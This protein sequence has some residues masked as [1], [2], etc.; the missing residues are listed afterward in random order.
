M[1]IDSHHHFWNYDPVEYNWIDD[2]MKQ[3]RRDFLPPD[4]KNE[5]S[6]TSIEGVISVQARQSIEETEW[7]LKMAGEN[8]FIKGVTGWLPLIDPMV[9]KHLEKFSTDN[10][11]KAVR[12]VL[13]GEANEYMLEKNFNRGIKALR[14]FD[15][16]YEILINEKQLK[17]AI[18]LVD[19]HPDQIFVLDHIAKPLIKDG[20]ISPW[21]ENIIELSNRA[22]VHCKISG[23]VTEADYKSW[24]TENLSP[25][26]DVVLEAFGPERLL[27]GSDWPVCE[28]ACKYSNWV[29][30]VKSYISILSKDESEMIMGENAIKLYNL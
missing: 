16:I 15:L 9:E 13:Q 6:K 8:S 14:K 18:K 12:H 3:I 30:L 21:K 17:S 4:L 20:I 25:Y 11:F 10:H 2:N 26:I 24:T 27:F 19:K 1:H 22:N 29:D 28:V 7:L 5:L 23:L